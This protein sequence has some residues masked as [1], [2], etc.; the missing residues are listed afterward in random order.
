MRQGQ[1]RGVRISPP[2]SGAWALLGLA[3]VGLAVLG[4]YY[5]STLLR[6]A[7]ATGGTTNIVSALYCGYEF[8]GLLGLGPARNAIRDSALDALK[9]YAPQLILGG[10]I[11]CGVLI[12]GGIAFLRRTSGRRS[13]AWPLAL[14]LLPLVFMFGMGAVAHFRVLGRHLIALFPL[15]LF[16]VALALDALFATRRWRLLPVLFLSVWMVS[17]GALRFSATHHRED[18]RSAAALARESLASGKSV[19]WV[20]DPVTARYYGLKQGETGLTFW[21]SPTG[22]DLA[23]TPEPDL[24]CLSKKD[25][26]DRFNAVE[27]HLA[28]HGFTPAAPFTAFTVFEKRR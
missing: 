26:Y 21:F 4:F 23:G 20:A 9:A 3:G 24:V 1:S 12:S 19:W 18:Y 7:R 22:G 5:L 2:S 25:I 11:V 15:V 8:L 6:G 14:A 17:A 13:P 28:S 16:L 10:G 27:A